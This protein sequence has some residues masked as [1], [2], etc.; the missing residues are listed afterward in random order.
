MQLC[1]YVVTDLTDFEAELT[2][3]MLDR[4]WVNEYAEVMAR[5]LLTAIPDLT[6]KGMCIAI[7]DDESH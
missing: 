1:T 7:Y 6:G 2:E 5:E 3:T 4:E